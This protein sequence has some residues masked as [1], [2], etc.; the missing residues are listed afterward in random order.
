M[1]FNQFIYNYHY[2]TKQ[3]NQFVSSVNRW[4]IYGAPLFLTTKQSFLS[5]IYRR[6]LLSFNPYYLLK[7]TA[8]TIF[9]FYKVPLT[10]QNELFIHILKRI[11]VFSLHN[12]LLRSLSRPRRRHH[13]LHIQR[14]ISCSQSFR[15]PFLTHNT[16]V[17]P[18]PGTPLSRD[19]RPYRCSQ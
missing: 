7:Y 8:Y 5:W 13:M 9:S 4:L 14:I 2:I 3:Q 12:S 18:C 10:L 16:P 1:L 6:F 17:S 15:V 19:H 11:S